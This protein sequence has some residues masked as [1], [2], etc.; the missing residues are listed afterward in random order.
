MK[1]LVTGATGFIGRRVVG[2]LQ[3]GGFD[4]RVASRQPER[5]PAAD[6]AVRLP[7]VDA[8]DEA[9]VALM[10]DVT[11]VVHCA[12]LNND[13]RASDA[14]CQAV[15]A[16]L[17]GRLARA[18]AACAGGRFVY[19]SSIRAVAGPR[20]SGTIS[21]TTPP[22]P[23]CAYGRSKGEGEVRMLE[24]YASADRAGATALRLPPVYGEGMKGNL[25]G[26]MRVAATALPLPA[27]LLT[28]VRS[29]LSQDA[30]AGAVAHLLT[31]PTP[32]RPTYVL[33]DAS[34]VAMSEVITAFRRGYGVPARF[35]A[36]PA[37]PFRRVAML[38]GRQASYEAWMATQICDPSPL[39]S[40]GWMPE[41]DTLGRLEKLARQKAGQTR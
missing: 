11:H 30:V 27:G 10:R 7:G 13:R 29:L 8:A 25:R 17:T 21:E 1:V 9:F 5:L 38:L 23:Q 41:A 36:V 37:W 35:L 26:L 6:D 31:R 34:P 20:F 12:A 4:V 22:A 19:L 14:D 15:N 24:A 3:E 33:A 32:P 28:G 18:A 40:E 39:I 2:R 16:T